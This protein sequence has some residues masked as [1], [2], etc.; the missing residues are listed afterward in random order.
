MYIIKQEQFVYTVFLF[1]DPI[2]YAE[3][4][5]SQIL[6]TSSGW[7]QFWRGWPGCCDNHFILNI[8]FVSSKNILLIVDSFSLPEAGIMDRDK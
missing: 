7:L 6:V 8:D 4:K 1:R 2:D 5:M 3:W